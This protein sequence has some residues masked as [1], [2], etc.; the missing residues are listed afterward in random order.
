MG[1]KKG[2]EGDFANPEQLFGMAYSTCYLSALGAV[3]GQTAGAKPLPKSTTVR[4]L[5]SVGNDASKKQAV[6]LSSH[7]LTSA[8][9]LMPDAQ[10]FLLGVELEVLKGP[11]REAGLDDAAMEKLIKAAHEMCPY[12]RATRG[13]IVSRVLTAPRCTH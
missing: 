2:P 4:A 5:V 8:P 6:T 13:N 12:S 3:Q 10:G 11:L 9:E 7:F 1:G